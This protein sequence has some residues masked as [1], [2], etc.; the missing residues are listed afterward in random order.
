M[1]LASVC[2]VMAAAVEPAAASPPSPWLLSYS[3]GKPDAGRDP[4]ALGLCL[5]RSDGSHAIRLTAPKDDRGADWS[6][7]GRQVAFSRWLNGF[8][9]VVADAAG[10]RQRDLV[11]MRDTDAFYTGPSWSPDGRKIAFSSG[12][13]STEIDV[14]NADG[15]GVRTVFAPD[16]FNEFAQN[17]SWSPD[18]ERL[19]FSFSRAPFPSSLYIV[20]ADGTDVRQLVHDAADPDWSPD[21]RS[22]VYTAATAVAGQSRVEVIELA[23]GRRRALTAGLESEYQPR[24]SPDG[25][26][27]AFTQSAAGVSSIGLV[28]RDGSGRRTAVSSRYGASM[29]AWRSART[30]PP[31]SRR[32]VVSGGRGDDVLRGTSVGDLLTGGGG[33]DTLVGGGGGDYLIGGDGRDILSGGPGDDALAGGRGNDRLYGHAGD[34]YLAGGRGSDRLFGGPGRDSLVGAD[35][36]PDLLDGGGG[37]DLAFRDLALDRLL[38]IEEKVPR[39]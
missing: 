33:N 23:S 38:S 8:D 5:A 31:S 36:E 1:L 21:G 22:I 4:T 24:W 6:P 13:H 34:D 28:R 32:C 20:N 3:L 26:W 29:P 10:R 15:S 39:A 18:G 7:D 30:F 37:I 25:E 19:V 2:A 14:M 12:F 17:P 11:G 16:G 27:I 9:I 35:G